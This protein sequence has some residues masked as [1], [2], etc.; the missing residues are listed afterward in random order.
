LQR[1]IRYAANLGRLGRWHLAGPH[2][3]A[4]VR[5][6]A[7]AKLPLERDVLLRVFSRELYA[8][9]MVATMLAES[10]LTPAT[11]PA[12]VRFALRDA[13]ELAD[14]SQ[15]LSVEPRD[16]DLS[17]GMCAWLAGDTE[18]ASSYF[19]RAHRGRADSVVTA[20]LHLA[21]SIETGRTHEPELEHGVV[22]LAEHSLLQLGRSAAADHFYATLALRRWSDGRSTELPSSPF[23]SLLEL[24]R[25]VPAAEVAPAI[26][27]RPRGV[28]TAFDRVCWRV[29]VREACIAA[30]YAFG[31]AS[32]IA[33]RADRA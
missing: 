25:N 16:A 9:A 20:Y 10:T 13:F 33:A 23:Q 31:L 32:R 17:L 21:S 19:E 3:R 27:A 12:A 4:C 1:V 28:E 2:L 8:P 5:R 6:G 24:P 22:Q 7:F 18:S 11:V 29:A 30:G 14:L 15:A 26:P